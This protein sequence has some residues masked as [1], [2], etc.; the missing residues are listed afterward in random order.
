M[1]VLLYIG[2][3]RQEGP[4]ADILFPLYIYP[5]SLHQ[6][7]NRLYFQMCSL[8]ANFYIL[9]TITKSFC[10]VFH[11]L[12]L[13]CYQILRKVLAFKGNVQQILRGLTNK[14]K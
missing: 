3:K 11:H 10:S 8:C 1:S 7:Q 12:A 13:S 5:S 4:N 2:T 14:L 9:I 6:I